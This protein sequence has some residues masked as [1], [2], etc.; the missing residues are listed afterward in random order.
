[1]ASAVERN[2]EFSQH[3]VRTIITITFN[4]NCIVYL[5]CMPHSTFTFTS[6]TTL[7]F[8]VFL[9]HCYS[10]YLPNKYSAVNRHG[11]SYRHGDRHGR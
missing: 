10:P 2:R 6:H 4:Y 5:Y 9:S 7:T 8:L 3:C 11:A 1:M